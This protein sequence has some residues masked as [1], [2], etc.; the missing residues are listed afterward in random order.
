M[1]LVT[2]RIT[3]NLPGREQVVNAAMLAVTEAYGKEVALVSKVVHDL[4]AIFGDKSPFINVVFDHVPGTFTNDD[5][6]RS[7]DL[8][9]LVHEALAEATFNVD[10]ITIGFSAVGRALQEA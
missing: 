10:R 9:V 7:L 1:L 3:H 4:H 2:I 8:D 5:H 6:Q